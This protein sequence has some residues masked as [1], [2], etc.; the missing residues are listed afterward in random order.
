MLFFYLI[1]YFV[2]VH[3]ERVWC[4]TRGRKSGEG[5]PVIV[6]AL[7]GASCFG[8]AYEFALILDTDLRRRKL[9][10]KVP[11]TFVTPEPYIGHLGLDGV[12]DTKSLLESELRNR[13]IKWIT[14]AKTTRVEAGKLVGLRPHK[15]MMAK[16]AL[17]ASP[18]LY[19]PSEAV[20]NEQKFPHV[21]ITEGE[22]KAAALW[23]ANC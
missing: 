1:P 16:P 10:H 19:I 21:T 12:G 5:G 9:R 3:G 22:F 8:P 23:A 13:H 2:I 7:P 11:M 20:A 15:G 4:Y 6:G 18:R 17:L 14:N